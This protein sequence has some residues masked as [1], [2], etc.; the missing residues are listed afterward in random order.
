MHD[1]S[2]RWPCECS[3]VVCA[4]G[5]W[6]MMAISPPTGRHRECALSLSFLDDSRSN[7]VSVTQI[8]ISPTTASSQSQSTNNEYRLSLYTAIYHH[9]GPSVARRIHSANRRTLVQNYLNAKRWSGVSAWLTS[10]DSA[11]T[12]GFRRVHTRSRLVDAFTQNCGDEH[13]RGYRISHRV[14]LH[15]SHTVLSRAVK[16]RAFTTTTCACIL[17]CLRACTSSIVH[18]QV[19]ST[20]VSPFRLCVS[21]LN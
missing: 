17:C 13:R 5:H 19:D 2:Q 20:H 9:H 1:S 21:P 18:K 6:Y 8:P 14:L 10:C 11:N 3:A 7:A 4:W 15:S 16:E 12:F